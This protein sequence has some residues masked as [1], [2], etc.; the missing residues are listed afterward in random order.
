[1][2]NSKKIIVVL[3]AYN[4]AETL[5]KTVKDLPTL[6]DEI[7]LVDDKSHDETVALARQLGLAVF[8]ARIRKPVTA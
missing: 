7:I 3:P 8:R 5:T 4:A 1:M 2:Y 6:V